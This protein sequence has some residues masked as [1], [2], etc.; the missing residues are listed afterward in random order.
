MLTLHFSLLW[1]LLSLSLGKCIYPC[2]LLWI[3]IMICFTFIASF[4]TL[5]YLAVSSKLFISF[6]M[7][8]ILGLRSIW[9][10][11]KTVQ[12]L[13]ERE[14]TGHLYS[15]TKCN[16]LNVP[17]IV[18]W[19]LESNQ[20]WCLGRIQDAK[21]SNNISHESCP[22]LLVK[23]LPT[24]YVFFCELLSKLN[25]ALAGDCGVGQKFWQILPRLQLSWKDLKSWPR[26]ENYLAAG[27]LS[28]D[29]V[30]PPIIWEHF[31]KGQTH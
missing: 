21:L 31:W 30:M 20:S 25:I 3:N 2:L 12:S 22:G 13:Q 26:I 14:C 29:L 24:R 23:L 6:L 9:N 17:H 1:W 27:A 16:V 11:Q 10:E 15:G 8:T 4:K 28:D 19:R 5:Y 18:H 7:A